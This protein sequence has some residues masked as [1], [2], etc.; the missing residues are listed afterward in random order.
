MRKIKEIGNS[1][2]GRDITKSFEEIRPVKVRFP[3]PVGCLFSAVA[4]PKY[5]NEMIIE[6]GFFN[7]CRATLS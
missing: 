4:K 2:L 7:A 6:A 3:D 5:E 1:K